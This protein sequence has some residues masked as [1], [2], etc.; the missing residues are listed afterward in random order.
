MFG[1]DDSPGMVDLKVTGAIHDHGAGMLRGAI[2]MIDTTLKDLQLGP[3]GLTAD[4]LH[5]DGVDRLEVTFEG[6]EPTS[7]VAVIHRVTATN[8][9]LT[10]R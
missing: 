4:R 2:G 5:V 1:G 3:I 10:I 6:F 7:I 9:A 8:L